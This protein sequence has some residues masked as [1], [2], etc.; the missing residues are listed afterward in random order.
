MIAKIKKWKILYPV[1]LMWRS[2][3]KLRSKRGMW[4]IFQYDLIRFWHY[5]GAGK[6]LSRE[7]R[8]APIVMDYHIVEKGLT[9]PNRRLDFGHDVVSRLIKQL[10]VFLQ[11]ET[12]DGQIL[13]AIGV[14]K[15][16]QAMHATFDKDANPDYWN[17]LD[18]FLKKYPNIPVANQPHFTREE[19]YA[20]A[21]GSFEAFAHSRHTLRHYEGSLDIEKVRKA[22]ALATTAPSACNRQHCRVYVIS[23]HALRDQVLAVQNGNRGFGHLADKLIVLTADLADVCGRQERTDIFVNGG[24][25]LMNLCYALHY[26]EVAHCILNWSAYPERDQELRALLPIGNSETPVAILSCGEAPQ[27]FDVAASPRKEFDAI[28]KEI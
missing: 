19:F 17:A 20:H 28:Y 23:D 7:A 5:S 9:M 2:Y 14:L 3:L 11:N 27:E 10:Q 1:K 24:I 12:M 15:A 4:K 13:H 6:N 18:S 26:Y 25:F 16:Y 22:V 8:L 21:K